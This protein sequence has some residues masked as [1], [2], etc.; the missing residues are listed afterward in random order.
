MGKLNSMSEMANGGFPP[1]AVMGVSADCIQV[2]TE[3]AGRWRLGLAE[4]SKSGPG[5]IGRRAKW[6]T[7]STSK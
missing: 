5:S 6:Q 3:I 4:L 7:I 2:E 1:I